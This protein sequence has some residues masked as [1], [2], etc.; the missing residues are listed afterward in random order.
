MKQIA[1][2]TATPPSI[3]P[4]M[5]ACEATA[6]TFASRAGLLAD[7]TFFRVRDIGDRL[8]HL[9][10]RQ[11]ADIIAA[12]DTGITFARL[13]D[14]SQL[15][16]MVPVFW[17]DFLHMHAYHRAISSAHNGGLEAIINLLLLAR[18]PE[19]QLSAISY[20]TSFLFNS[21]ADYADAHYGRAFEVFFHNSHHVQMRDAVSA[22]V[23]SGIRL[24]QENCFG[25]DPAQLLSLAAY[26][27]DIVED[28]DSAR[29]SRRVDR[30][31]VFFARGRHDWQQLEPFLDKL[32]SAMGV[33]AA[34]IPW[35]DS[36]SFPY[37]DSTAYRSTIAQL[38]E[39]RPNAN[40]LQSLLRTIRESRC[41]I[42]DTY[43]LAVISWA[44]GVPA[45]VIPGD[46]HDAEKITKTANVRVRH[47]KRK[48]ILGQDGLLDFYIEPYL[49]ASSDHWPEIIQR[50]SQCVHAESCGTDFRSRLAV[51]AAA[52]EA[53]LLSAIHKARSP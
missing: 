27:S 4:G 42:T 8:Q 31:A 6:H 1:V 22:A 11:K 9:H 29:E 10:P 49:I 36:L 52:S 15:H 20:G 16:D 46:Y 38:P 25:I 19:L 33:T 24:G 32:T 40:R 39:D 35:G 12:C 21:T 30:A 7:C 26:E 50:L 5:L 48:V 3:N 28:L 53:N 13:T 34:W 45:V 37:S 18:N 44:I 17:G 41:V 14:A 47:D 23:V 43:H 2:I 51:R